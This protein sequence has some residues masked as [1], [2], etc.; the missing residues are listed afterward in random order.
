M[1][2]RT[3]TA[4]LTLLQSGILLNCAPAPAVDY[5]GPTAQWESY[6]STAGGTRYSPLTQIDRGNVEHL[7]VAWTYHTG[8]VSDGE[9]DAPATNKSSFQATPI[10]VEGTM[11]VV[12]GFSRVIALDPETGEERWIFDPEIDL[13]VRYSEIASRGVTTWL[14]PGKRHAE[15]CRRR[16]VLAD[17]A[18]R[19][20]AL[21]A[22][23]GKP[24]SDFGTAGR[25]D[26]S[27]GIEP[28]KPG[29]YGVTSPPVV[30]GDV[31]ITGSAIG[32]NQRVKEIS[33]KVRGYDARTGELRWAWDPIP[34]KEGDPGWEGWPH[35][36]S[37]RAGAANAWSILS[38]DPERDLVF[39][40]TGSASPDFYGGERPGDNRWSS[41]VVALRASTGELVWGFQT[42]HHDIWDYDVASQPTLVTVP[43]GR[44]GDS[45]RC[46]ADENGFGVSFGPGD[47]G[48]SFPGRGTARAAIG[49]AG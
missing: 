9:E 31:L 30:I 18:A 16:I 39:V 32:D 49:C 35:N 44:P 3:A 47:R 45:S 11:Y 26:L 36:G 22:A 8:D 13:S 7:E 28:H 10:V 34:Q 27:E 24:C 33:G 42:V 19:L 17:R 1:Y 15:E 12:T 14:D 43:P 25:V 2:P 41:S 21:D 23:T 4:I 37:S 5:S 46:P 38:A 20:H 29:H 6:G 40:P 48:T